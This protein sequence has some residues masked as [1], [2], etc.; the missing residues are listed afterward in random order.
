MTVS[1][2]RPVAAPV[3]DGTGAGI[4]VMFFLGVAA[5][6]WNVYRHMERPGRGGEGRGPQYARISPHGWRRLGSVI[7]ARDRRYSKEEKSCYT[8]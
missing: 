5:G 1:I 3:S 8:T 2:I 7:S 4:I 6:M